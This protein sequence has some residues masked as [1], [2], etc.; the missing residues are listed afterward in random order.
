MQSF[1]IDYINYKLPI[2]AANAVHAK[3]KFT[4]DVQYIV[5][6]GKILPLDYINTGVTQI[7]T[8]YQDGIHQFL[9][10]K[11]KVPLTNLNLVTNYSSNIN[12]F[13]RY[14]SNLYGLTG[15]LG[16]EN[17]RNFLNET[18]SV[19][20]LYIPPFKKRQLTELFP[21]LEENKQKWQKKVAQDVEWACIEQ[22]RCCLVICKSIKD[23]DEIYK[24][25]TDRKAIKSQFIYRY[26]DS[27]DSESERE[28]QKYTK[29]GYVIISTNLAGR[30]CD[31]KIPDI[32][33]Q[34]GGL[35]VIV[36]FI[37]ENSR[38]LEQAFGR[39]GRQGQ[40]G[41]AR[42]IIESSILN[43]LKKYL[44]IQDDTDGEYFKQKLSVEL[45]NQILKKIEE[46]EKHQLS[47]AKEEVKK[48]EEQDEL[49]KRFSNQINSWKINYK[50][51]Y[52]IFKALEFR[53]GL[54]LDIL[55]E[56]QKKDLNEMQQMQESGSKSLLYFKKDIEKFFSDIEKDYKQGQILIKP[57]DL[58]YKSCISL[59]KKEDSASELIQQAKHMDQQNP[60]PHYQQIISHIQNKEFNK[61][62]P[63]Y[64]QF[65][66][67][68][69]IKKEE[70]SMLRVAVQNS[71]QIRQQQLRNQLEQEINLLG[72]IEQDLFQFNQELN[73]QPIQFQ[74]FQNQAFQARNLNL[75]SLNNLQNNLNLPQ[76]Q[77]YMIQKLKLEQIENQK[78]VIKDLQ[79]KLDELK[80]N[81][82]QLEINMINDEKHLQVYQ[83]ISKQ[84]EEN[85]S[86]LNKISGSED[87]EIN[88]DFENASELKTY[89]PDYDGLFQD[90]TELEQMLANDGLP[91]IG[92]VQAKKKKKRF[93][94][95][96]VKLVA[97]VVQIVVGAALTYFSAGAAS[98]VGI[99]LIFEGCVDVFQAIKAGINNE[100]VDLGQYFQNKVVSLS[101]AC[102]LAGS[103]ALAET[104]QLFKQGAEYAAKNG[105]LNSTK[106]LL[107]SEV[108]LGGLKKAGQKAIELN[109][110]QMIGGLISA[111][112][113]Q[114]D[115]RQKTQEQVNQEDE[116]EQINE[117][118]K[119]NFQKKLEQIK[120]SK[121]LKNQF[122]NIQEKER[123]YQQFLE[124]I[125]DE[126]ERIANQEVRMNYSDILTQ[127]VFLIKSNPENKSKIENLLNY[128]YLSIDIEKKDQIFENA[129]QA[130][131]QSNFNRTKALINLK[132]CLQQ[133]LDELFMK[134]DEK[135]STKV[136]IFKFI[137]EKAMT[138][139]AQKRKQYLEDSVNNFNQLQIN[140][141][142]QMQKQKKTFEQEVQSLKNSQQLIQNRHQNIEQRQNELKNMSYG[143]NQYDQYAVNNYNQQVRNLT[144]EI[145]NFNNEQ[146][147]NNLKVQQ[148][149]NYQQMLVNEAKQKENLLKNEQQKIQNLQFSIKKEIENLVQ[150]IQEQQTQK[151]YE[152]ILISMQVF[153]SD[154]ITLNR[155]FYK[156]TLLE[157]ELNN[158]FGNRQFSSEIVSYIFSQQFQAEQTKI[159]QLK[160]EF[161]EYVTE[162]TNDRVIMPMLQ[163][164]YNKLIKQDITLAES[165]IKQL[166]EEI[167]K[168]Q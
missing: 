7:N 110:I 166:A 104:G 132:P 43:Q 81:E 157:N 25:I 118:Q 126:V 65:R 9:Q 148:I 69:E 53:F 38:V 48:I 97:G 16:T 73:I 8:Q 150:K 77:K 155:G 4:R 21:Y 98:S 85:L 115:I 93:W 145:D 102:A 27:E 99:S 76:Q 160:E 58:L 106:K 42:M 86:Q 57:E 134:V 100:D 129:S 15:T 144:Q 44:N 152:D 122:I 50:E 147:Q 55:N 54:F 56:K 66:E 5:K 159:L 109:N 71:K 22:Q 96:I 10:L 131:I 143:L 34:K 63:E 141:D 47:I 112:M 137:L 101:L 19:D 33:E 35:H 67:K 62:E 168:N 17:I 165:R 12:F 92:K 61:I 124:S 105:I 49:F 111:R 161:I 64:K 125:R 68:I 158:I 18:Y 14:H 20:F 1:I 154:K 156:K 82:K 24:L 113:Q 117:E 95:W 138:Q 70:H 72:N 167:N 89:M 87:Y 136:S 46:E 31:L 164:A 108:I 29:P 39:A 37:P 162:K 75:S 116:Q 79:I 135:M 139:Y 78:Q 30:G 84:L 123:Q 103:Q 40:K 26:I 149:Q 114:T 52:L 163:Q 41:S 128:S 28:I 23:V 2:W 130:L 153:N 51:D 88:V 90:I 36:T 140:V 94:G 59:M 107:S 119:Q 83:A 45:K 32:V 91:L 11:E 80:T 6:N 74:Q 13:R 127:L 151:R 60:I 121:E 142:Q 146:Q 3:Y 120:K 133:L